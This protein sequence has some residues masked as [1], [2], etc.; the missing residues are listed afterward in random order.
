MTG[1]AVI[2]HALIERWMKGKNLCPTVDKRKLS[3]VQIWMTGNCLLSSYGREK[4]VFPQKLVKKKLSFA[5]VCIR[6]M[7]NGRL[8]KGALIVI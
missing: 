7:C 8:S 2:T 6:L 3:F 5:Q 1:V 4:T